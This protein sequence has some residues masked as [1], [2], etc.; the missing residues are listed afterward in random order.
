MK[1]KILIVLLT[2]AMGLSMVACS[3]EG[4]TEQEKN[5]I[6]ESVEDS[7]NK[8]DNQEGTDLKPEEKEVAEEGAQ[9][10]FWETRDLVEPTFPALTTHQETVVE[11]V[12]VTIAT[13]PFDYDYEAIEAALR[14]NE[15]VAQNYSLAVER[16]ERI[17]GNHYKE[18]DFFSAD[19]DYTFGGRRK[20]DVME[21][22]SQYY[23]DFVVSFMSNTNMYDNPSNVWIRFRD[24][25]EE[26]GWQKEMFSVISDVLGEEIAEYLV[27]AKDTANEVEYNMQKS[28]EVNGISYGLK[29]ELDDTLAEEG[30]WNVTFQLYVEN[31]SIENAFEYHHGS[32][33]ALLANAKYNLNQLTNGGISDLQLDN[34]SSFAP[35]Y[36]N[37]L[38]TDQ[39]PYAQT[40]V[41]SLTYSESKTEEGMLY[42]LDGTFKQAL[43][44]VGLIACPIFEVDYVIEEKGVELD[45]AEITFSSEVLYNQFLNSEGDEYRKE[46]LDVMKRQIAVVLP[47][48]DI[49]DITYEVLAAKGGYWSTFE[50]KVTVLG[51]ECDCSIKV[52]LGSKEWTVKL[53]YEH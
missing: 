2:L 32:Y 53:E 17:S 14:A 3:S 42:K 22:R 13:T 16:E 36:M 39:F 11:G 45:F 27:Y 37:V 35:E 15:F 29:R 24:M 5:V 6:S 49:S 41:D 25:R 48:V 40:V 9:T 18:G 10:S 1:K 23:N 19:V 28:V 52:D 50:K 43:E 20:A 7:G 46:M 33:E 12:E 26:N 34:F 38:I 47:G 51:V 8:T 21:Y 31:S 4:T 30:M 44:N